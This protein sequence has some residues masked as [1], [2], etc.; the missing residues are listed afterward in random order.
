MKGRRVKLHFLGD[1]AHQ[2]LG[3]GAKVCSAQYAWGSC[4][5]SVAQGDRFPTAERENETLAKVQEPQIE[6]K[7]SAQLIGP[8]KEQ[9]NPIVSNFLK[10]KG[11][12][13][14]D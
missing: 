12:S 6:C 3:T 2:Y 1:S 5:V 10:P 14:F 13:E 8:K 4:L 11:P 9:G 7:E